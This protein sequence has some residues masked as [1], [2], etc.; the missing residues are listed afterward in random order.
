MA[1]DFSTGDLVL[2]KF[3]FGLHPAYVLYDNGDLDVLVC[4]ITS[5]QRHEKEEIEIPL[6]E[7]N[8]KHTSYI[9]THKITSIPKTMA[10]KRV[11]G[12][13]SSSFAIEVEEKLFSWLRRSS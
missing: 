8:I 12:K 10:G 7:G 5:T 11:I 6:G 3:S 2:V 9:R 4:M 1:L 13:V